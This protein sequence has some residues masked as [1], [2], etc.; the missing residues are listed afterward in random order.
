VLPAVF[1]AAEALQP[2][3]P[4]V[5]VQGNL[6]GGKTLILERGSVAQGLTEAAQ[7]F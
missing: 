1:D 3:A 4:P 5:H 7:V 2:G 6:V